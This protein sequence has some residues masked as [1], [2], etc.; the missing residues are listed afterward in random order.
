MGQGFFTNIALV[1]ARPF[2]TETILFQLVKIETM[3]LLFVEF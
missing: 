3:Q 2:Q 1:L